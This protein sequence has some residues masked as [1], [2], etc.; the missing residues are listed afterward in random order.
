MSSAEGY[1]LPAQ[2][3]ACYRKAASLG[4][5][6]VEE[7]LDKGESAK[8]ADRP[9]LQRLLNY[10]EAETVDYV[11]VHKVD[12]LARNRHDDMLINLAITTAGAE[13]V[14]VSENIDTTPSGRLLHGIVATI[15]EFHSANLAAEVLKG[16]TQKAKSGGTPNLAPIGYVNVRRLID[17][18]E[19]R[20]VEVDPDRAPLV[21]YAFKAYA[22]GEFSTATLTDELAEVG[23]TRRATPARPQRPLLRGQVSK[24]LRNPYYIG[25]VRY[26]GQ[27]YEGKHEPI[28]PV[29]VFAKVQELLDAHDRSN[30]RNRLHNHYLKGSIFC[31]RCGSRMGVS[32]STGRGGGVYPYFFCLGRQRK[33]GCDLPFLAIDQVEEAVCRVYKQIEL[34]AAV[35]SGLETNLFQELEQDRKTMGKAAAQLK[36]KEDRLS[37][38]RYVWA[39]K[40]ANGSVPDDIGRERQAALQTQL[41]RVRADLAKLHVAG[42]QIEI[43]VRKAIRL[44]ECCEVAYRNATDA[45]RREWNQTVFVR[46]EVDAEKVVKAT[47]TPGFATLLTVE[48]H[49]K[50]DPGP[51]YQRDNSNTRH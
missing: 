12:R 43:T 24:M 3:E 1:S 38:Q 51:T 47:L 36:A 44:V 35:Q 48:T 6:V 39:E 23:L 50:T 8:T 13:L 33:N 7:F 15:A 29:E 18:R 41:A 25:L 28:V 19:V 20:S 21:E 34:K 32:M 31:A 27:T 11:I 26:R 16:M 40:V 22:T 30:S 37:K 5:E 45:G 10:L 42:D 9:D 49:G 14:S 4:A 17:G 2:R 46:L